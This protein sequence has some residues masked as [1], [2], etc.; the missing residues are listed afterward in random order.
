MFDCPLVSPQTLQLMFT[1]HGRVDASLQYGYGWFL[2]PRFRMHGGETPGFRAL[3][4]QYLE[5]RVSVVLLFNSDHV[6]PWT[7][8]NALES[9]LVG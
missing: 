5:R 2:G 6:Q 8:C 4:R 1:P 3:I 9:L 7:V